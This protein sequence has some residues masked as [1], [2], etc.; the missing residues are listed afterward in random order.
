MEPIT[1]LIRF[2]YELILKSGKLFHITKQ[3][4]T[5]VV[6]AITYDKSHIFLDDLQF[7]RTDEIATVKAVDSDFLV[8]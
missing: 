1:N 7:I 3:T 4:A 8:N 2:E 5:K 6:E